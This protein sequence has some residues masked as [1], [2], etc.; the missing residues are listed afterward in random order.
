[1]KLLPVNYPVA[2][3]RH[4]HAVLADQIG[5]AQRNKQHQDG[6]HAKTDA[7]TEAHQAVA[8]AQA[9]IF[10]AAGVIAAA[11]VAGREAIVRASAAPRLWHEPCKYE[12][13]GALC[14]LN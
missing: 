9:A 13:W 7:Q 4:H 12:M 1:M 14:D 5:A 11:K 3:A 6:D 2:M 8:V 10:I